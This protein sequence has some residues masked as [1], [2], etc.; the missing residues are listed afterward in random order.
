MKLFGLERLR[1]LINEL[2][3]NIQLPFACLILCRQVQPGGFSDLVRKAHLLKHDQ[4]LFG[5]YRHHMFP[6]SK[7]EC[8]DA[9]FPCFLQSFTKKGIGFPRLFCR[10]QVIWPFEKLRIDLFLVNK[11]D[12]IDCLG[13]A[14]VRTLEILVFKDHV[15]PFPVLVAFYNVLERHFLSGV[16]AYAG[17]P[18]GTE[19]LTPEHVQVDGALLHCGVK[20]HRYVD[21]AETDCP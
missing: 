16:A 21:Q 20:L 5:F 15:V 2:Y 13:F 12:N 3:R 11:L 4:I 17:I 9:H 14:D 7:D 18:D 10:F 1:Q 8:A 6:V 19:V